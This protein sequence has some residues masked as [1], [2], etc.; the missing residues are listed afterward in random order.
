MIADRVVEDKA[1]NL[2]TYG[3]QSPALEADVTSNKGKMSKLLIG[4][5]TADQNGL[6]RQ[7]CKAIR[8]YSRLPAT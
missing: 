3:L 7:C 2:A 8:A 5:D 6:V 1:S 4:D